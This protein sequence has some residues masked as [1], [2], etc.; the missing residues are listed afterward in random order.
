MKKCFLKYDTFYCL[1]KITKFIQSKF[2]MFFTVLIVLYLVSLHVWVF[3]WLVGFHLL[4][5]FWLPVELAI[6]K[7]LKEAAELLRL[8]AINVN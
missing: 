3:L 8:R 7:Y 6:S 5:I 2:Y 4:S 1:T